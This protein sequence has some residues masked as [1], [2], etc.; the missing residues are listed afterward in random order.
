M[1]LSAVFLLVPVLLFWYGITRCSDLSC[2]GPPVNAF[3]QAITV[4]PLLVLW[5]TR[6]RPTYPAMLAC[7]EAAMVFA[8]LRSDFDF[9]PQFM[10]LAIPAGLIV[11]LLIGSLIARQAPERR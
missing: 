8:T 7:S 5:R 1:A 3:L 4:I 9:S 10:V 6:P 11:G 2:I